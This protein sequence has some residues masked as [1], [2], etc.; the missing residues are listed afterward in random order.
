VFAL[1]VVAFYDARGPITPFSFPRYDTTSIPEPELV[2]YAWYTLWGSLAVVA[3]TVLL[4]GLPVAEWVSRLVS[5]A[6][7][8]AE[9]FVYGLAGLCLLASVAFR[10]VVLLDQPV[11]DDEST[12]VFIARTLLTGRL[13]N[14]LPEDPQ[15]FTNQFIVINAHGWHGKYPIG[16]PLLL[17]LG[18][19][20]GAVELIVPLIG[21]LCV[22]LTHRV[23]RRMFGDEVG[24][25]GT[26]LL[27]LSPHFVWTCATLLSQ[28]TACA[29]LLLGMLALLRLSEAGRLRWAALAGIAFG[30]GVLVRPLP[31]TL[32]ALVAVVFCA[33]DARRRGLSLAALASRVAMV[34]A[35]ALPFLLA[36]LAVN[37]VQSGSPFHTGYH[38][39]HG[40]ELMRRS[41]EL[42]A[43]SV[44][45]ALIRESFWLLG[46][47]LA[48]LLAAFGRPPRAAGLLWG[49]V[50][51]ELAYRV[52]AP[53]TVVS[54]TGPIYLTEI[55]PLLLLAS[56]DAARRLGRRF[57]AVRPANVVLAGAITAVCLFAPLQVATLRAGAERRG[58]VYAELERSG[59][60][61]ALVFANTLAPALPPLTWAFFPDN[62]SPRLDDRWLFVRVPTA[63]DSRARMLEL[64]SRRFP[65]RRAFLFHIDR[66]GEPHFSELHR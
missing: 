52:L 57:V 60:D 16:H 12:Y 36:A 42:I 34:A 5:R 38:D 45:G 1:C 64:W 41:A 14:P 66:E 11:A 50:A 23:G 4:A 44:A 10:R 54:V 13:T 51:A 40:P 2:F 56:A 31:G 26:G 3:L 58:M 63:K 33:F 30:F 53:K 20:L 8:R 39:V 27:L 35:G 24:L 46:W 18:E 9:A 15:F 62:P 48:L 65:D 43:W 37:Y 22:V 55:V 21:A 61:R 19:A 17:A 49:M 59:A 32:F 47:P 7:A 6:L 28:P 29:A 25:I